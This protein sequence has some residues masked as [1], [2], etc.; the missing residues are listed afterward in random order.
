V[1]PLRHGTTVTCLGVEKEKGEERKR[2]R[3]K[4]GMKIEKNK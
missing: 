1:Q 2:K 4:E 3:K